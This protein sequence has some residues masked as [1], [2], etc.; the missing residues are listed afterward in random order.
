MSYII[1]PS[2]RT[3]QPQG[4]ARANPDLVAQGLS[5]CFQA[6][7][8]NVVYNARNGAL[9]A[10]SAVDANRTLSPLVSASG[11]ARL[12]LKYAASGAD[13][14]FAFPSQSG[15][16]TVLVDIGSLAFGSAWQGFIT[17]NR[18]GFGNLQRNNANDSFWGF[19]SGEG[20]GAATVLLKPSE[21]SG[22]LRTLVYVG[23]GT[24]WKA[25][26][27]GVAKD[28]LT[29]ASSPGAASSIQFARGWDGSGPA[30]MAVG[31]YALFNK[32]I[33]DAL[34]QYLSGNPDYLL[35]SQIRRIY[36]GASGGA[37]TTDGTANITQSPQTLTGSGK[38]AV[39][40]TATIS[41]AA[42]TATTA[43]T[44]AIAGALTK[45][46]S[47]QTV[48]TAGAVVVAG[49]ATIIPAAQTVSATGTVTSGVVGTANTTPAAQT[50]TASGTVPIA[51]T[52]TV[53][54]AAQ[55]LSATAAV[56]G[57]TVTGTANVYVSAQELVAQANII[58]LGT[59]T[60]TPAPQTLLG[61]E[62]GALPEEIPES[63]RTLAAESIRLGASTI[64]ADPQRLGATPVRKA[65][66]RLG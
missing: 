13:S 57:G 9:V 66:P 47:A 30:S 5:V 17:H 54:P 4:F 60:I 34:A 35:V 37:G 10:A 7:A 24:S 16:Y 56:S 12:G 20:N 1:I 52:A 32:A 19:N 63:S 6:I 64:A 48:T 2:W 55:T 53:T 31:R 21:L 61:L 65:P 25:W 51:A 36:F 58:V 59:A 15:A 43:A 38:V 18:Y 3:R 23:N 14:T 33:P 8:S 26:L 11:S 40:A 62:A 28:S 42:Q 22:P 50:V 41:P 45:T 46:P 29:Y 49:T 27:D 39:A 44:V